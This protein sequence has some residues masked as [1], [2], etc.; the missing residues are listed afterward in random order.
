MNNEQFDPGKTIKI[1]NEFDEELKNIVANH[2]DI[3]IDDF[4]YLLNLVE[5]PFIGR[6]NVALVAVESNNTKIIEFLIES[7]IDINTL[8]CVIKYSNFKKMTNNAQQ[9]VVNAVTT[10]H[11]K[12]SIINYKMFFDIYSF[13]KDEIPKAIYDSLV[14]IN[15]SIVIEGLGVA[16]LFLISRYLDGDSYKKLFKAATEKSS[17][18]GLGSNDYS[19]GG[20]FNMVY[21]YMFYCCNENSNTQKKN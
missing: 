16:N 8:Y 4:K 12:L 21:E 2:V 1:F 10:S 17:N 5:H 6:M 13:F 7:G 11:E 19:L 9:I 3:N 20:I 18:Y 14:I 15:R